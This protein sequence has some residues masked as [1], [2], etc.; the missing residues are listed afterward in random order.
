MGVVTMFV[1]RVWCLDY[2]NDP[3]GGLLATADLSAL[4]CRRDVR[5]CRELELTA[6]S[7]RVGRERPQARLFP[8]L[9]L[10]LL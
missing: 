7:G 9:P 6:E 2:N 8:A 10:P 1:L 3:V 4:I 5:H